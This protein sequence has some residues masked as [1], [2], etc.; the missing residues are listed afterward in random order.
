MLF[1]TERPRL[2]RLQ[3]FA[4]VIQH[5]LPEWQQTL[6]HLY[7][8]CQAHAWRWAARSVRTGTSDWSQHR[9]F[10]LL[11]ISRVATSWTMVGFHSFSR[12]S[13]KV[14]S[15]SD[16]GKG[17]TLTNRCVRAAWENLWSLDAPSI[18]DCTSGSCG[19]FDNLNDA[20]CTS[21]T[22]L[23]LN[24]VLSWQMR[25]RWQQPLA[26]HLCFSDFCFANR[27]HCIKWSFW[28]ET[29]GLKSSVNHMP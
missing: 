18:F 5:P 19:N 8:C 24:V 1:Q 25:R 14:V 16:G 7:T 29:F 4:T 13:T 6:C 2:N 27:C 26:N 12:R 10:L 11:T 3:V 17:L 20:E 15:T 21:I 23:Q 28:P 22:W 9:K